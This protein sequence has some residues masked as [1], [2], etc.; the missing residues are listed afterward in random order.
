MGIIGYVGSRLA[1]QNGDVQLFDVLDKCED[2]I[3]DV[4]SHVGTVGDLRFLKERDGREL[5]NVL[6]KVQFGK[7]NGGLVRVS[8]PYGTKLLTRRRIPVEVFNRKAIRREGLDY[9]Y[10]SEWF[11]PPC[12]REIQ[13]I[14][15]ECVVLT[16]QSDEHCAFSCLV[17]C[18]DERILAKFHKSFDRELAYQ[19][20]PL[21][22]VLGGN[23]LDGIQDRTGVWSKLIGQPMI[24]K[25]NDEPYLTGFNTTVG[26]VWVDD[27]AVGIGVAKPRLVSR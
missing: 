17:D 14:D 20:G 24:K 21:K 12:Y 13:S 27:V 5:S 2:R 19:H 18:D 16:R 3:P 8:F 26:S 15:S 1:R 22:A 4:L 10:E 25:T 6:I 11:F 9:V 7:P 23:L